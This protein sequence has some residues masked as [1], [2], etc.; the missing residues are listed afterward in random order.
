[1]DE[2]Y[3]IIVLGTF[4]HALAAVAMMML[5]LQEPA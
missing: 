2:E 5:M 1:M 3:D 4:L